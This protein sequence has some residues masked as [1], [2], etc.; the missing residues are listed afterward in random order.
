MVDEGQP[1]VPKSL[2]QTEPILSKTPIYNRWLLVA[3]YP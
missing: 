2:G 3:P 1:L